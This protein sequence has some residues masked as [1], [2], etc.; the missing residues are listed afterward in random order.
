[1]TV[2]AVVTRGRGKVAACRIGLGGVAPAAVRAASAEAALV[3]R[4]LDRAS[5]GGGGHGGRSADIAPFDDS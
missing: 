2:A 3:G 1:M 4:P 5:G